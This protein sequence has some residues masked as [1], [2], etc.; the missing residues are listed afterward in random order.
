[1][2]NASCAY[3]IGDLIRQ[4]RS[5][6]FGNHAKNKETPKKKQNIHMQH[7]LLYLTTHNIFRTYFVLLAFKA[8]EN[9]DVFKHHL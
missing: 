6:T 2:V 1:M 3:S 9:E 4:Q 7:A 5:K 8:S